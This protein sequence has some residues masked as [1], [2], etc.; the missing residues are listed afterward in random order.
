MTT[1]DSNSSTNTIKEK[2]ELTKLY[3]RYAARKRISER[4]STDEQGVLILIDL[5]DFCRINEQYGQTYADSILKQIG[6]QIH[7]NFMTKDI[8]ARMAF[9]IF[10][11]YCPELDDIEKVEK[12]VLK[13]RDR[14]EKYVQVRDDRI[15]HFSAGA[16]L[17]P[18]NGTDLDSLYAH[19]DS[20]LWKAKKLGKNR[21]CIYDGQQA[22]ADYQ[23]QTYHKVSEQ[24]KLT[25]AGNKSATYINRELFDYCFDAL[26]REKDL[27]RSLYLVFE[28][29]CRYFNFGRC[30]LREYDTLAVILRVTNKWV[31]EDDGDDSS[32]I[33]AFPVADFSKEEVR[34]DYYVITDGH[35]KY[36]DYTQDF[37][38]LNKIPSSCIVFPMWE[39]N[40]MRFAI[41]YEIWENRGFTETEIST[42]RSITRML[43]S[44]ILRFQTKTELENEFK[45]GR[46]A[47]EAQKIDY[48]VSNLYT[49]EMYYLSPSMR[50]AY[51]NHPKDMKCYEVMFR[52][53]TPCENCP[54]R[55][56]PSDV[57]ENTVE[58]YDSDEDNSYTI[59]ATRIH[60]TGFEDDFLICKSDVTSYLQRIKGIDQLTGVMS[61]EKFRIEALR[62]LKRKKKPFALIFLGIQDF[63]RI[64]DEYGYVTGD[65][66]LKTFAQLIQRDVSDD[67]LFCRVKGD[68][69]IVIINQCSM[70]TI[71][72]RLHYY[73]EEL[74]VHFRQRYAGILVNCFGGIYA[75][76]SE[77][78]DINRSIDKAMKARNL[79][80][81]NFYETGG[82]YVYSK[83][84]ETRENEK[85][86]MNRT[87]RDSLE[88]GRFCVYF[89][90]KVDITTGKLS[91]AEALVR[92]KD[93][94]GKL[95]PPG[96]FVPLAEESGLIVEID[97]FVYEETFRLM[98][99]WLDE[100]KGVP[101][102]SVNLS[103]LHLMDDHLPENMKEL[104]GSYGLKP[105]QIE[106]EI[107]ESVFF[108]DAERLIDMIKRL[109]AV[110]FV[111]SMDDFGAGYSTLNFMKSLPVDIIKIDG[112]FFMKNRMD[113]KNKAVISAVMQLSN[114]LNF[115][116]VSEGV[117][118]DEQVEFIK[119][120]G[121]KYVQG[122]YF[123]KPLPPEEFEQLLESKSEGV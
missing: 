94:D 95:I 98:R 59:T 25:A 35:S 38:K 63:A 70:E 74:T 104:S 92:L 120:Q 37:Q 7:T 69:F 48:F 81:T 72:K 21:L 32:V 28:E 57:E 79:A 51:K 119:D 111:I 41:T 77:E 103:R 36:R 105:E 44:F 2:D 71:S 39:G 108:Q 9:D 16:A 58:Y 11:V 14:L 55:S 22:D 66:V 8:V 43:S 102:V 18:Q 91:G 42:L 31:R 123:Y 40:V 49:Y 85:E 33:E 106:L 62:L 76:P 56:C 113:D 15:I 73:T 75:I 52:R 109:K 122:Y 64:N 13:L 45:V 47:M 60:E 99:Q 20:A 117:E 61:Y 67:E 121:G 80:K 50:E 53:D 83:E 100:G 19:A 110:G 87:M 115:R 23:G 27:Q 90:P 97:Q 88:E 114:N 68:D 54:M 84:F 82:V 17:F 24:D 101:V 5:D 86:A 30:I 34:P 96:K 93:K 1:N 29:V 107:T 3:T 78:T 12:L 4:M 46:M 112:G 118:T 10:L 89:Q 65:E 6:S 116:T 26:C